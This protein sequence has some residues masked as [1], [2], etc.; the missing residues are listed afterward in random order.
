MYTTMPHKKESGFS[1]VE[2]LVA[3]SINLLII[4]II[5][6][7]IIP[8]LGHIRMIRNDRNLQLTT[9]SLVNQLS[10]WIKQASEITVSGDTLEIELHDNSTRIITKDVN[11]RITIFNGVSTEYLTAENIEVKKLGGLDLFKE[12]GH[13][14]KIAFTLKVE[15]A[16][17]AF[18]AETTI[19]KR[20]V[21]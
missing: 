11:E 2:V 8:G 7:I 9:S 15:N 3:I 5:M 18:S 20:N 12:M 4:I 13:S 17:E 16:D 19:A 6:A 21:F 1:L 14:I 10:Y